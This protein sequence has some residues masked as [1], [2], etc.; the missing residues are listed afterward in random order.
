VLPNGDPRDSSPFELGSQP[1]TNN[2]CC[3]RESGLT[4]FRFPYL[5]HVTLLAPAQARPS[6]CSAFYSGWL[7][8]AHPNYHFRQAAAQ[9]AESLQVKPRG[10]EL[11]IYDDGQNVS[12]FETNRL[13][14]RITYL[15]AGD[16]C[17]LSIALTPPMLEAAGLERSDHISAQGPMRWSCYNKSSNR[18]LFEA[19]NSMFRWYGESDI[20]YIHLK[21]PC[22]VFWTSGRTRQ[23]GWLRCFLQQ[24]L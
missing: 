16:F 4:K 13:W 3:L 2:F 9:P 24:P 15:S 12:H 10:P 18:E 8:F 5:A 22:G 19:I 23:T 21:K 14:V 20:C 11:V 6:L 7:T 1:S 17:P